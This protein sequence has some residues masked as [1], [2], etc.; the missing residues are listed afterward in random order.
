MS[1]YIIAPHPIVEGTIRVENAVVIKVHDDGTY[2]AKGESWFQAHCN[3]ELCKVYDE[4]G[5]KVMPAVLTPAPSAEAL[6]M[7]L[8]ETQAALATMYET[9]AAIVTGGGP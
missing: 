1:L 5:N 3:P 8:L 9:L 2:D 4:S 6:Q 7:Q